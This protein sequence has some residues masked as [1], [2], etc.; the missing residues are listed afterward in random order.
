M[1]AAFGTAGSIGEVRLPAYCC[2]LVSFA[3][4]PPIDVHSALSPCYV[5]VS[6]QD[7]WPE[8]AILESVCLT[9]QQKN[10]IYQDAERLLVLI[11]FLG[12]TPSAVSLLPRVPHGSQPAPREL[13]AG[14]Q[15]LGQGWL[16]WRP[17]TLRPAGACRAHGDT[18]PGHQTATEGGLPVRSCGRTVT[19]CLLTPSWSSHPRF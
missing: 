16:C 9:L 11:Q 14:A 13:W 7:R 17:A 19:R 2:L 15:V 1:L 10:L 6:K 5:M 3:E 4:I 8:G 12:Y 18:A